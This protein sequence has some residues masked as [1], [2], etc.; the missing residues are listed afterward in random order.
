MRYLQVSKLTLANAGYS[1]PA[2]ANTF[3]PKNS[4]RDHIHLG[5]PT[6][7]MDGDR[8]KFAED[9][10]VFVTYVS[11]KRDDAFWF[12]LAHNDADGYF[13]FP[14]GHSPDE[15]P[16]SWVTALRATGVVRGL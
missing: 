11:F 8:Q 4:P 3:F 13:S 5:V 1:V 2:Q 7:Y 16:E 14:S 10:N 15:L 6:S 9:G 12:R